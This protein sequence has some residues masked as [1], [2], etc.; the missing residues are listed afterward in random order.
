MKVSGK[1]EKEDRKIWIKKD[2]GIS[3][4]REG[5]GPVHKGEEGR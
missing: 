3:E 2:N 5:A 4:R 1:R